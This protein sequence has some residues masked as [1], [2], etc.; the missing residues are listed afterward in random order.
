M[1]KKN[2]SMNLA[3]F[4]IGHSRHYIDFWCKDELLICPDNIIFAA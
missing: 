2:F 1:P 4:I 3:E